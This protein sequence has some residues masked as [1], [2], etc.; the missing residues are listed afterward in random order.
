[1]AIGNNNY[2]AGGVRMGGT[3]RER[4]HAHDRLGDPID[5]E[6]AWV[7]VG[8]ECTVFENVVIHKPLLTETLVGDRVE[9]GAG[10]FVGHDCTI[11][12][13]AVLSPH[14]ATGAYV[15][16]GVGANLGIGTKVH[17]RV[18]IGAYAMCGLASTVVGHVPPGGL[19]YGSPARLGGVN[20]VGL[21][22][23][24]FQPSVIDAAEAALRQLDGTL[25]PAELSGFAA[26]FLEATSRWPTSKVL[27]K[28]KQ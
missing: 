11:Y 2:I 14:T 5:I 3:S 27:V 19:V 4:I 13:G 12:A 28:W 24:G 10:T 7:R 20:R 9:L 23:H 17:N 22:R 16:V 18:A 1:M 26:T 21:S 25:Y 8:D 15:S 6:R